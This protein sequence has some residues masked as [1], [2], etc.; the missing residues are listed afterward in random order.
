M[1]EFLSHSQCTSIHI[2]KAL[3]PRRNFNQ[4]LL[5]DDDFD[6]VLTESQEFGARSL[7]SSTSPRLKAKRIA[8]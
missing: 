1:L 8:E 3:T 4:S 7:Q 2:Q 6:L 5:S